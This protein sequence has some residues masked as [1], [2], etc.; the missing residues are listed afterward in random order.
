M[1]C[2]TSEPQKSLLGKQLN[3]WFG[4]RLSRIDCVVRRL[5]A[6]RFDGSMRLNEPLQNATFYWHNIGT[7]VAEKINERSTLRNQ[8]NCTFFDGCVSFQTNGDWLIAFAVFVRTLARAS[9]GR[10]SKLRNSFINSSSVWLAG[11]CEIW[12][13]CAW[14]HTIKGHGGGMASGG[15][16]QT[17]RSM[18]FFF[19]NFRNVYKSQDH[20]PFASY[21]ECEVWSNFISAENMMKRKEGPFTWWKQF[22]KCE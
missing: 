20:S 7:I 8:L 18:D 12:M 10:K 11:R 2:R 15:V 1:V 4:A 6:R 19:L 17:R 13:V 22:V 14:C 3:W 5:D 9:A 21:F 16:N